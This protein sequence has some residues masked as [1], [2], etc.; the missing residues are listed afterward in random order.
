MASGQWLR[1]ALP[2]LALVAIVAGLALIWFG[3]GLI[4]TALLCAGGMAI[5]LCLP[6]GLASSSDSHGA[7]DSTD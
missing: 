4:A 1:R 7:S 3:H 2:P 6:S 5:G